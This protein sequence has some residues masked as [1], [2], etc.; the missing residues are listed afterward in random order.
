MFQ[1][2][3][4]GAKSDS[5]REHTFVAKNFPYVTGKESSPTKTIQHE[6]APPLT[7]INV[8]QFRQAM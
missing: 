3:R 2:A 6:G 4:H 8:Y 5:S 1:G 7:P